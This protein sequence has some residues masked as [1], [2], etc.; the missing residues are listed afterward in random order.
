MPETRSDVLKRNEHIIA[1][2]IDDDICLYDP[3]TERVTVL[4]QT[5]TDI[6]Y[7]IDGERDLAEIV[8]TL[9]VSY[10]VGVQK[11]SDEVAKTVESLIGAKLV[12]G[13]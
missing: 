7:L 6:W 12:E 13:S 1:T 11:I 5:A 2:E 9:A 3:L 4:N 10:G 8:D